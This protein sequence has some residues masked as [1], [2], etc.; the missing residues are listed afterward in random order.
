MKNKVTLSTV[1]ILF[2]AL[3]LTAQVGIGTTAPEG[4]LDIVS[5]NSGLVLPRNAD[6]DGA[7]NVV[8]T[9]DDGVFTPIEGM[10]VYDKAD[11]VI[12]FYDGAKWQV[13]NSKDEVEEP[14]NEGVIQINTSAGGNPYLNIDQNNEIDVF[15]HIQYSGGLDYADAPVT[16]WP[17]NDQYQ[18]DASVYNSAEG[19]FIENAVLGQVHLWRIEMDYVKSG[20]GASSETKLTFKIA[21]E[22]VGS[23]FE[24]EESSFA[25]ANTG[26]ISFLMLTIAD[27]TSLP[28]PYGTGNGYKFYIK[29]SAK[30]EL[31]VTQVTRI[32][33]HKD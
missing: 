16:H 29:S 21:N 8:G 33:L 4:I 23:N 19:S 2:F 25:F 1:F 17:E 24:L 18:A 11:K 30:I 7:D 6:P 20:G 26:T 31:T 32:S 9:A 14:E 15:Q 13:V 10:M 27:S 12:R 5:E 22:A 3:Q 28:A